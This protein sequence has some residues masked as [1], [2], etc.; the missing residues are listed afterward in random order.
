MYKT[1]TLENYDFDLDA[2]CQKEKKE[3][4]NK[5]Y[6]FG[7]FENDLMV[8]K[9]FHTSLKKQ[10]PS[11]VFKAPE[12]PTGFDLVHKFDSVL[13]ISQTSAAESK[14][15]DDAMNVYLKSA[16]ERGEMLGEAFIKP[17]SVLDLLSE[18]DKQFIEQQK[19]KQNLSQIAREVK[20]KSEEEKAVEE[21]L[22][23]QKSEEEKVKENK[24]KKQ[25]RYE[26]YLVYMKK[27]YKDPYSFVETSELTEWEKDHEKD[28]FFRT[29]QTQT[30]KIE[31]YKASMNAKF[32]SKNIL[33]ETSDNKI[34]ET[35]IKIEDAPKEAEK[36]FGKSRV[37]YE[38]RPHNIV[39]KRFNVPNP[40]PDSKECGTIGSKQPSKKTHKDSSFSIFDVLTQ[41]NKF[42]SSNEAVDKTGNIAIVAAK[43]PVFANPPDLP[44]NEMKIEFETKA[45]IDKKQTKEV[46][47]E[48]KVNSYKNNVY[49]KVSLFSCFVS[50]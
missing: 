40:Y 41:Q 17:D 18:K 37:E 6:G 5:T 39:C 47:E 36:K 2:K 14:Q 22:K 19:L 46:F 50:N 48:E 20:Q 3:L 4:L 35:E 23:K 28:E 16:T 26:Q 32:S 42:E 11:K 7:A 10:D 44:R 29:Y 1:D 30:K 24:L 34:V 38:W 49:L 13:Q 15:T 9:K 27:N 21:K 33:M 25:K 12:V 31:E 43:V 45:K 8:L